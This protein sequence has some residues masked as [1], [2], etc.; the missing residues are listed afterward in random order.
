M[1]HGELDGFPV[2]TFA[3]LKTPNL[4]FVLDCLIDRGLGCLSGGHPWARVNDEKGGAGGAR[5]S[6][7]CMCLVYL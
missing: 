7:E 5:D 6:A 3:N 4:R 1:H 2:P